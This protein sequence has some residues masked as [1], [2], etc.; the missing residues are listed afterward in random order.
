MPTFFFANEHMNVKC[1][2]LAENYRI[3]VTSASFA[4][5]NTCLFFVFLKY[6][7]LVLLK[8]I[9]NKI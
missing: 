3:V 2:L 4:N 1:Y 8:S 5:L 6:V 7:P 9:T